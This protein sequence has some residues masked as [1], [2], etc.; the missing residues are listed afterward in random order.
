MVNPGE[1]TEGVGG[2][3][4]NMFASGTNNFMIYF[5]YIFY[6]GLL[7][8]GMALVYFFI[9]YKYKVTIFEG[10]IEVG[11]EGN[12]SINLM[13]VKGDRAKPA[14]HKGVKKWKLMFSNKHIEP[15]DFKY[16]HPKNQ[17]FLFRT[18]NDVFNPIRMK[19][20][21]PSANFVID[22]F[23]Q[24]FFNLGVQQDARDYQKDDIIKKQ[25]LVMLAT[26]ILCLAL[27]G[28]TAYLILKYARATAEDIKLVTGAW[29][30]VKSGVA[31][32]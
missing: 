31:P 24:S 29:E 23:D 5:G 14:T 18:A 19:M 25:Q 4:S 26:I 10:S 1:I 20:G 32:N 28:L 27:V 22:P 11:K 17:V 12:E 9:S 2:L 13:R 30:A 21:N 7:I 6:A 15:I 8:G 3:F 16:I